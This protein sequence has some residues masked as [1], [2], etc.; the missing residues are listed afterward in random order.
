MATMAIIVQMTDP[1]ILQRDNRHPQQLGQ[2]GQLGF[3][4]GAFE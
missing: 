3:L 4:A 2:L 1:E